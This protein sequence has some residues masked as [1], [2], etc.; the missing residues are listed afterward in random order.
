MHS[1][2]DLP[3]P[4]ARHAIA[5]VILPDTFD[6]DRFAPTAVAARDR[7]SYLP[8]GAGGRFCIGNAFAMMEM[9]LA[10]ST[11]VRRFEVTIENPDFTP[12][13][14]LTLNPKFPIIAKVAERQSRVG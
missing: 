8:F 2:G 1:G 5:L 10:L 3:R 14:G 12:M 13:S 11:I 7:N 9:Q 6:P 4:P